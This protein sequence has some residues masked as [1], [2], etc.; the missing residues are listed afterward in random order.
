M[1][2]KNIVIEP[3]FLEAGHTQMETDAMYSTIKRHLEKKVIYLPA[4]Y[5]SLAKHKRKCPALHTVKYLDYTYF[6]KF[7]EIQFCKK[8]TSRENQRGS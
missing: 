7:D 8:F 6:K 2:Q 3:K 4:E 1:R 5:V